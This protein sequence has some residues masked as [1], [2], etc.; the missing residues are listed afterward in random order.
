MSE[1]DGP[2]DPVVEPRPDGNEVP[3]MSRALERRIRQQEILAEL[4]VTALQ[5][6]S[7]D[8][9]MGDAARL[10]AEGMEAEFCKVLEHMPAQNCFLV[11]AGVGWGAGVVGVATIGADLAS[12][13]G[14]ALRTG[15]PVISNHLE[16]EERF[17]TPELLVRYGIH[18]AM[19]VILQGD[20]RPFGVLEV[21]SRSEDEFVPHDLA[22][23]QGAAN[24]LGMAIE[25]ERHE[26]SLKAALARQ[27][28][29]LKEITH[30]VKNSLSIVV[31]MLKVQAV[32]V[33]N[34]EVT[35]HL[36]EA[37][38]RILAVARAHERIHQGDG[39]DKLDL[40]LYLEQVCR[41]LDDAVAICDIEVVVERGIEI[42]TDRAIPIALI[43]NELI[44]NA[45]KHAHA[46]GANGTILVRLARGHDE[47]IELS[48]EDRGVGL[49]Q[50][51]DLRTASGL[52]MRI[53]QALSRQLGAEIAVRRLDPGAG[54]VLT[55]PAES[56]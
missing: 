20:G 7:F 23:L 52:G 53:V 50:G 51:F 5:G 1:A 38:Y 44:T 8:Q 30:R 37:A 6:A 15:K 28:V 56:S 33:K 14:F 19:N 10:T 45:A 18:R 36:E 47:T 35:H 48:I 43:A 11:R 32:D 4:G 12:P 3:A 54:F 13:A 41:D 55:I 34:P 22:F 40:G 39:T 46:D 31:S 29:L 21:D 16:N 9:L 2:P 42:V 17:R 24:I 26:R 27:Q 25:R 49:P